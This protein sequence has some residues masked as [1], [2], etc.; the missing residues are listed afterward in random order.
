MQFNERGMALVSVIITLTVLLTLANILF[1][2]VWRSIQQLSEAAIKDQISWAAQSGIE[3]ARQRLKSTYATSSGWSTYLATTSGTAYSSV[4]IWSMS[5]SE[6][7]VEIFLRDNPDGDGNYQ[8][9]NDLKIFVLARASKASTADVVIEALCG[10]AAPAA[11][12]DNMSPVDDQHLDL[13]TSQMTD[14]EITE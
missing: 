1:E 13:S 12:S 10:F 6:I 11:R 8:I 3:V 14:Y 9:D 7:N 4:P 5:F 2:K